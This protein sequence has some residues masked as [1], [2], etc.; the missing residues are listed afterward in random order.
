MIIDWRE[1]NKKEHVLAWL[2]TEAVSNHPE[3]LDNPDFEGSNIDVVLS[4]NGV[5][6]DLLKSMNYL[7]SQLEDIHQHGVDK[8]KAEAKEELSQRLYDIAQELD[9]ES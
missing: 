4:V 7:N 6:V 8:G 5:E 2:L 9:N 3:I 1:Y